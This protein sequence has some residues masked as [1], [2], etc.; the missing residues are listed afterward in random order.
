METIISELTL[1]D[2]MSFINNAYKV[3]ERS[4][5]CSYIGVITI[6]LLTGVLIGYAISEITYRERK[7]LLLI[8]NHYC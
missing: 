8:D 7:K 3:D 6:A 5:Q 2:R 4:K 1:G